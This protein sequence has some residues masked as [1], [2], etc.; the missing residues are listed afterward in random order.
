M[1]RVP[2]LGT[3][4]PGMGTSIRN[5]AAAR[6]AEAS[7][8]SLAATLFGKTRRAILSL[9]FARP[10]EP[11]YLRQLMRAAGVGRG[12]VQR[13]VEALTRAGILRRIVRGRQ[14]Y[15]EANP[16]CAVFPELRSLV[17]KTAGVADVLR[18]ALAPLAE[19]LR[20][21]FVYGSVARGAE[22]PG[23]DV[24]LM[25]IG[26][27][28]FGEVVA[29]L[30]T[31]QDILGREV[32]PTVYPPDEFRSKRAGRQHFVSSVLKGEKIFVVGDERELARLAK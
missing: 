28:G 5:R 13:E 6:A 14:V 4:V 10:G 11:F 26:D 20:V 21:A 2:N 18:G 12:T 8:G 1:T 30:A 3:L 31:A 29:A 15:Y 19:R 23:S 22:R 25:V 17:V 32:N 27:A 7:H 9:T 24:D 16:E